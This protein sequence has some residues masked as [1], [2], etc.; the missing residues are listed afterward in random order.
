MKRMLLRC[1]KDPFEVVSPEQV[2]LHN[3][4][5]SN[6]GNLL[7]L[8]AAYKLLNT[9]DVHVEPDRF[10]AH[11]LG[12]DYINANFDVYV[13]PLA[14]GFRISFM[15][16]LERLTP[17]IQKLK[18]PVVLLSGGLQSGLAYKPGIKRPMDDTVKA[19]VGAIMDKSGSIGLRG[20]YSVDYV[21]RLGFKDVE[22]IG[23]P[24]MFMY[25]DKLDVQ[26]RS[27]AL[28]RN[29]RITMSV[30][31]RI[32]QM[33]PIV[34][35]H[36]A[37]YPNLTYI[38]QEMDCLRLLLWGEGMTKMPDPNPL[39]V[40]PSH[41]LV[42]DGKTKMWVDPW[43]WIDYLRGTDF[44]FG[45]RIHG[46]IAALLA[47]TPA[48][49]LAHDT[50]TTELSR[51]FEIPHRLIQNTPPTIDAADLYEEADFGPLVANHKQRFDTYISYVERHG[52]SHVFQP[53]EDPT[54]FD[55]RV[56]EVR[57]PDSVA[58]YSGSLTQRYGRRAR[59]RTLR[60]VRGV[61]RRLPC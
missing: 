50:R 24:S 48:Y 47:G 56:S 9:K 8:D 22:V 7:F 40:W 39:P 21:Q 32:A 36:T 52:L 12:A 23:C 46:N 27:A 14:N 33:A 45:S 49:V 25:G 59:R 55:K 37:K 34:E 54:R 30:T 1:P 3:L 44:T 6:T 31:S 5:G 61:R 28:D 29:S 35:S 19:F 4:I 11:E 51:Y 41:P 57:Y 13:I 42:R 16:G 53:G 20:E 10:K 43:P 15:R 58:L 26:K 17:V 60:A 38:G 18:I 2:A